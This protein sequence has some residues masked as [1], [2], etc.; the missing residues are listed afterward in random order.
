[1]KLFGFSSAD[2]TATVAQA[3]ANQVKAE[4][5]K[6]PGA[7]SVTSAVGSA[8]AQAGQSDFPTVRKVEV[9]GWL[10]EGKPARILSVLTG[11]G[12]RPLTIQGIVHS[13][14]TQGNIVVVLGGTEL[15]FLGRVSG[16]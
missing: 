6:N 10:E 12:Y 14:A 13:I 7:V 8:T 3:R 4:L 15:V 16:A 2:E 9:V 11:P 1:V 5:A